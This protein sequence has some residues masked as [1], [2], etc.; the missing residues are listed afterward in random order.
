MNIELILVAEQTQE[1][2]IQKAYCSQKKEKRGR[3][4]GH[5]AANNFDPTYLKHLSYLSDNQTTTNGLLASCCF[6]RN[7]R[8]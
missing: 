1:Q 5:L 6:K 7:N 4:V 8:K 3:G 2:S